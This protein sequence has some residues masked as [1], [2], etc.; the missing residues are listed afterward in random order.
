MFL[1]PFFAFF[2]NGLAVP[3]MALQ[4][5]TCHVQDFFEKGQKIPETVVKNKKVNER[6]RNVKIGH[7]WS[8]FGFD[9]R[10]LSNF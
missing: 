5:I 8:F 2:K 4:E 6:V 1:T 3:K 9:P 7:F 10:D